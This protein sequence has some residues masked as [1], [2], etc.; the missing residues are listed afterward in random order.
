MK[1]EYTERG[2]EF[3]SCK[4]LV[5]QSSIIGDYSDSLDKPGCSSLWIG[6]EHLNREEV[7]D[8]LR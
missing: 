2:F 7:E 4:L 5:Q 8:W 3:I 6:G 1:V